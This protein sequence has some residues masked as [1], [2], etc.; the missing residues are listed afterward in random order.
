[1]ELLLPTITTLP[2]FVRRP[3]VADRASIACTVN[4]PPDTGYGKNDSH[5]ASHDLFATMNDRGINGKR[6]SSS[7][8]KGAEKANS[9]ADDEPAPRKGTLGPVGS[10]DF[11]PRRKVAAKQYERRKPRRYKRALTKAAAHANAGSEEEAY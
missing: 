3:V 7:E 2:F 6:T 1:M 10:F 9:S 4:S 11:V 8:E 5:E